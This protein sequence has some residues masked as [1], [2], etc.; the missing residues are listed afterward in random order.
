M[1]QKTSNRHIQAVMNN[2]KFIILGYLTARNMGFW[3]DR[4]LRLLHKQSLRYV[5]ECNTLRDNTVHTH[6]QH[7]SMD[8]NRGA[9]ACLE[10]YVQRD[11]LYPCVT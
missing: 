1:V 6:T 8:W 4:L 7:K 5:N 9:A 2:L 10:R 3:T 11:M